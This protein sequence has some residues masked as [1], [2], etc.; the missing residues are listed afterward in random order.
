M[1][2]SSRSG[3]VLDELRKVIGD[4]DDGQIQRSNYPTWESAPVHFTFM[5]NVF[6]MYLILI[7]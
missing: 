5:M 2:G 3:V 7:K 6:N 4:A 1:I